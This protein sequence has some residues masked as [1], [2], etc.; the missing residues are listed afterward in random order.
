[1]AEQ[2]TEI[3]QEEDLQRAEDL[4][5]HRNEP[6]TTV[7]GY[8]TE[9]LLGKGAF[10]EVWLAE[11]RNTGRKM[12]IKFYARRG[13]ADWSLLAREVEKLRYL[14]ADRYVVQ[15]HEVGWEADPPYYV[16]EY[17]EAGSLEDRLR[18]G[19]MPVA[20]ALEMFRE[21][22]VGMGHAH[23][24][25]I[26]HC[27]LKPAN[28]L[29]DQD[30]KP[31]L[32]DFGQSRLSHEQSPALGT[33]FYMAPE[34][35]NLKATPDARWDV[36]AL[37]V[38]LYRMLT[39]ELPHHAKA[40]VTEIQKSGNLDERLARYS[41][42]IRGSPRPDAH[43]GVPGVDRRLADII[44]RCLAADPAKRFANVQAV[45]A[46]LDRRALQR[47]RRPLLILGGA[48]PLVLLLMIAFFA[49]KMIHEAID[50]SANALINQERSNN[51]YDAHHS[52]HLVALQV[53]RNRRILD[54]AAEAPALRSLL[55]Q[56]SDGLEKVID[57]TGGEQTE[58]EKDK[59]QRWLAGSLQEQSLRDWLEK[60][61][62]LMGE[63]SHKSWALF[64]RQGI[65][66]A[67]S[68]ETARTKKNI[69]L[70][71]SFRDFFHGEGA[72]KPKGERGRPTPGFHL[73]RP[74]QSTIDN[75]WIVAF[76]APVG[77]VHDID[78][79]EDPAGVI[80]LAV[81]FQNFDK[82]DSGQE[83]IVIFDTRPSEGLKD[84][85]AI[86]RH[87]DTKDLEHEGHPYPV[88]PDVVALVR[89][90][91][92]VKRQEMTTER[93]QRDSEES[94]E[95]AVELPTDLPAKLLTS[96]LNKLKGQRVSIK[97]G[98]SI[99]NYQDPIAA[100]KGDSAKWLAV[101]DAVIVPGPDGTF[102]DTGWGVV[103]QERYED[104]LRPV[105]ELKA[106]LVGRAQLAAGLVALVGVGTW[107]FV[108]LLLN[109][110]SRS[111][112]SRFLRK[113]AGL[114]AAGLS[115]RSGSLGGQIRSELS[116]GS[117]ARTKE[118][119]PGTAKSKEP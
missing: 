83:E 36:Y 55:S 91:A 12:A 113:R 117:L 69:G 21:V 56:V 88:A 59:I 94:T 108:L 98:L 119:G 80:M 101:V 111:R 6:P 65:M 44:D 11:N 49:R 62:S 7:P 103:V 4:S 99:Q 67:A 2:Q 40:Q 5:L 38:I 30:L 10:G 105:Q 79:L 68:P 74:F 37:G 50:Q 109:D 77:G 115:S 93:R 63:S 84:G 90:W 45:L 70:D 46:A 106:D 89:T 60:A 54:K 1:M 35:A 57:R 27:D 71:R 112:L 100:S 43:R 51:A 104:V 118:A 42:F 75:S 31:R 34:Q 58:A 33:L 24:K 17:L 95:K 107:S 3:M 41:K 52:A 39:G 16:M 82:V 87:P 23:A 73:S 110:S 13:G 53:D 72:D 81:T 15:L 102:E 85:G 116:G 114:A 78:V 64:S 47:A 97:Q 9:R 29:L 28:I 8:K 26:L 18:Q 22:A 61:H 25:G 92:E 48:V 66:L 76:S 20:E 32:A 96:E 86:V 19:T 14:A